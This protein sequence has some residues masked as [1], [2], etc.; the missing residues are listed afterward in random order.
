[1]AGQ[2]DSRF[3]TI[4]GMFPHRGYSHQA[5]H[6]RRET[7]QMFCRP[8]PS[9]RLWK[10]STVT[11]S[12]NR[13]IGRT[14]PWSSAANG[15]GDI[16]G[17]HQDLRLAGKLL[18]AGAGR[19][20]RPKAAF[21]LSTAPLPMSRNT[22]WAGCIRFPAIA[23]IRWSATNFSAA[24]AQVRLQFVKHLYLSGNVDWGKMF[25]DYQ[26]I[27]MRDFRT[28]WGVTFSADT[29]LGPLISD[30]AKP[31]PVRIVSTSPSVCSSSPA[32]LGLFLRFL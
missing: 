17:I 28:G 5:D 30:T 24:G 6:H 10:R 15:W 27:K 19:Q 20:F 29:P 2:A 1:M 23:P 11:P 25:D 8:S 18:A 32:T 4:F 22:I 13:A 26:D 14:W 16:R 9:N 7:G 12:P 31:P 3:G 21:G